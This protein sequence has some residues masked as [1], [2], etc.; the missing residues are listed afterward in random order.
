MSL[1]K[2]AVFYAVCSVALC[3]RYSRFTL[4]V[5]AMNLF[6]V[7][8]GCYSFISVDLPIRYYLSTSLRYLLAVEFMKLPFGRIEAGV[9]FLFGD[10]LPSITVPDLP[11]IMSS[12]PKAINGLS[13]YGVYLF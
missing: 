13:S 1:T 3:W 10:I 4:P 5:I 9:A 6:F 2:V 8:V 7:S 11:G 12:F